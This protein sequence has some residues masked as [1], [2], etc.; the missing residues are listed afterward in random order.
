MSYSVR[1]TGIAVRGLVGPVGS[2]ALAGVQGPSDYSLAQIKEAIR[3]GLRAVKNT[4]DDA[5]VVPGAGAFEVAAAMH[6]RQH[7][8]KVTS[9]LHSMPV[10]W[11][12]CKA[13]LAISLIEVADAQQLPSS[14]RRM[15]NDIEAIKGFLTL[16]YVNLLTILTEV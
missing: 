4:I 6:L 10:C 3:D 5:S 15:A 16:S 12:N 14:S 2:E 1:S 11:P 8:V 9:A 7:I 13:T